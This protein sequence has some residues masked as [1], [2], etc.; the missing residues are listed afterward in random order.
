MNETTKK[1]FERQAAWQKARR[2]LSW[3]EK[4][5]MAEAI[6]ETLVLLRRG[7]PSA[8]RTQSPRHAQPTGPE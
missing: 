6:R 2:Q 3:P 7:Q 8:D 5:A 1:L 4:I